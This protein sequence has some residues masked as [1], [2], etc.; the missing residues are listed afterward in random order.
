MQR[1]GRYASEVEDFRPSGRI[2][3][4]QW[5]IPRDLGVKQG[6]RPALMAKIIDK[7]L[8]NSQIRDEAKKIV[9]KYEENALP[10]H[11]AVSSPA[12][13]QRTGGGV[14]EA[15]EARNAEQRI[16]QPKMGIREALETFGIF[17][18]YSLTKETL[19]VLF[20][21]YSKSAHP[22]AGGSAFAMAILNEANDVLKGVAR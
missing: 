16:T 11:G 14:R 17:G 12:P 5:N 1:Y 9:A 6:E 15:R 21:H 10:R 13:E 22:D 20:R 8:N 18:G 2:S 3:F 19:N 7:D 4:S